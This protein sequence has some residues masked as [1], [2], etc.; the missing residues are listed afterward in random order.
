MKKIEKI[1]GMLLLVVALQFSCKQES[2]YKAVRQEVMDMHD[3]LMIDGEIAVRYKMQLDTLS[4]TGIAQKANADQSIDT[5]KEQRDIAVLIGHLNK[6]DENMMDWMH[7]FQPDIDGKSNAQAV[8]Y[9]K[10]EKE[11]LIK[12]DSLYQIALKQSEAYLKR[13]GSS[14]ANTHEGHDHGKH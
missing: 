6:A 4:K 13:F 11:K 3:K 10:G 5:A 1:A 8:A 2:D 7:A 9:F 14:L 12:M